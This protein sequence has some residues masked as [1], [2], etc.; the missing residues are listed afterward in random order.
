MEQISMRGSLSLPAVREITLPAPTPYPVTIVSPTR[1]LAW[2]EVLDCV[3]CHSWG[4]PGLS[5]R[6]STQPAKTHEVTRKGSDL[7]VNSHSTRLRLFNR[8]YRFAT[9]IAFTVG[10][11]L[12]KYVSLDDICQQS[13]LGLWDATGRIEPDADNVRIRSFV[14]ARCY[15]EIMDYMRNGVDHLSRVHRK[16]VRKNLDELE[17]RSK[18]EERDFT[19]SEDITTVSLDST[20]LGDHCDEPVIPTTLHLET[21]NYTEEIETQQAISLLTGCLK[22]DERKVVSWYDFGGL[23]MR[24]IGKRLGVSESR[25]CQIR[26]A[27]FERMKKRRRALALRDVV[28]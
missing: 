19:F 24:E 2:G 21:P 14:Y 9:G 25:V 23:K 5:N 26:Q 3:L 6:P 18:D 27:A 16:H 4:R 13:L 11:R 10:K 1:K 12:P 8:Y 20:L 15:G 22:G 17:K 28:V 7:T